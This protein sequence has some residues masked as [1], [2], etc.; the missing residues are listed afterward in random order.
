MPDTNLE[1]ARWAA[2]RIRAG[3]Y[4]HDFQFGHGDTGAGHPQ[5]GG[6]PATK[7]RRAPV[8]LLEPG[9]RR[10]CTRPSRKASNRVR[11]AKTA[12]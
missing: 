9:R 7:A 2:E 5:R 4:E 3:V 11:E 12:S 1:Q 10:P 6:R 8:A